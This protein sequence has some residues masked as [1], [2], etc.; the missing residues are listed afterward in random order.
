MPTKRTLDPTHHWWNNLLEKIANRLE[1]FIA[2]ETE[3]PEQA[4][5]EEL[6]D[7]IGALIAEGVELRLKRHGIESFE[8]TVTTDLG[9]ARSEETVTI[10]GHRKAD[11][12]SIRWVAKLTRPATEENSTEPGSDPKTTHGRG[13]SVPLPGME[14]LAAAG[15]VITRSYARFHRWKATTERMDTLKNA[16]LYLEDAI[17]TIRRWSQDEDTPGLEN[18]TGQLANQGVGLIIECGNEFTDHPTGTGISIPIRD[19][20]AI[21]LGDQ[22]K[23]Y[24]SGPGCKTATIIIRQLPNT[25]RAWTI[26]T[27]YPGRMLLS[28]LDVKNNRV[29]HE[30]AELVSSALELIA[31]HQDT[32]AITTHKNESDRTEP[33]GV[34]VTERMAG[35]RVLTTPK[36]K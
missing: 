20:G 29:T 21:R 18:L 17:A 25:R 27:D 8:V 1:P 13:P 23:T 2:R 15:E 31:N 22:P 4:R 12:A 5:E 11:E 24:V 28:A 35:G 6:N 33:T 34:V 7:V 30:T 14:R 32:Q 36:T 9:A 16:M 3:L 26:N 19:P 10:T